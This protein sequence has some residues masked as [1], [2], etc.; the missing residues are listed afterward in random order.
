VADEL[1][2][3]DQSNYFHAIRGRMD[4]ETLL[5]LV[6][7]ARRRAEGQ[8]R[9]IVAQHEIIAALERKGL[10]ATKEGGNCSPG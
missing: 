1:D 5:Q 7:Q 3:D 6:A 2:Q 10:D 4:K 9:D 8:D